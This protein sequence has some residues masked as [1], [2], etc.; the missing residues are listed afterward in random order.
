MQT[1]TFKFGQLLSKEDICDREKEIQIL[2]KICKTK[3]RA[4]VYGPRRYGKTSLVKN[5]VM[6]D[7]LENS[8]KSLAIYADFFQVDVMED[9]C[10]RLQIAFEQALSQ[11]AKVKSFIKNIYNYLKHFRVEMSVDPLSSAPAISFT[12]SH[13]RD[14]KM[15]SEIFLG[16]KN[17]S[18]E[19]KA[20]LILDEFQDV[21]YV[22]GL[23]AKLRSEIQ[24]L[25]ETSVILL[26]SKKHILRE[27]FH[28]E[29]RPFYG[30]GVDVELGKIAR[31]L[32][33]PYMRERFKTSQ[34]T[35][36]EEGMNDICN[37][38][39]DV[40]NSIQEL[41][42]W[43]VLSGVSGLLTPQRIE[44]GLADLIENK[45]SRF[46][47]R[48][49]NFSAKEKKVLIT[50]ARQE[51]VHLISSTKFLQATKVSATATKAIIHRLTDQGV[52]DSSEEGYLV[53][54]PIFKLFLLR[55][56]GGVVPKG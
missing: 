25:K 51:P 46:L 34:L 32:W 48:M 9:V 33:L 23:E 20:L 17:F 18:E 49:A 2:S 40:P 37:W 35:I 52:L 53:T 13:I 41:C 27:I 5:V 56:F 44:R 50:I 21:L 15:L 45:S 16:I 30:F 55:K 28:D 12:G 4:V 42:Q 47:E 31:S 19:Y 24:D 1:K 36:E 26:G 6:S 29:S 14:E 10:L 38:M 11:R 22:H 43:L 54:D 39:R 3:G 8:E 7:F